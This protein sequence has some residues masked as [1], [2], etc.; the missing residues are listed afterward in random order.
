MST[1]SVSNITDGTTTVGTGYVVN[2]SA[3]A[4]VYEQSGTVLVES[5]NISSIIDNSLGNYSHN[6]TSAMVSQDGHISMPVCR[7]SDDRNASVIINSASQFT[8]YSRDISASG[9]LEDSYMLA[10]THGDL[11]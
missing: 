1:L 6:L 11:A 5:F 2:G 8:S 7:T 3:K 4:W 10:T 9:A